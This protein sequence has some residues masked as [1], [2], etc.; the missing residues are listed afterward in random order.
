MTGQP[1]I[2]PRVAKDT[3][4]GR[5]ARSSQHLTLQQGQHKRYLTSTYTERRQLKKLLAMSVKG[6]EYKHHALL[7]VRRKHKGPAER[8]GYTIETWLLTW[9]SGGGCVGENPDIG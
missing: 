2:M 5:S 4:I 6:N 9:G 1:F 7:I 3:L 8:H